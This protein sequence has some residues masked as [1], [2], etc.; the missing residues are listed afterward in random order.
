MS[1]KILI[2]CWW[3]IVSHPY[4]HFCLHIFFLHHHSIICLINSRW[5]HYLT[6]IYTTCTYSFV[7]YHS[8][9]MAVSTEPPLKMRLLFSLQGHKC[10]PPFIIII[11]F[12]II[13]IILEII[14]ILRSIKSVVLWPIT[15]KFQFIK[16]LISKDIVFMAF[17]FIQ[18][19]SLFS[20]GIPQKY[21]F[22][23]STCKFIPIMML[24][25]HIT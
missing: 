1:E 14:I 17:R 7:S 13:N 25:V 12:N 2:H 4:S 9:F 20:I 3:N 18:F 21:I 15:R 11:S 6:I 10:T 8:G 24:M 23:T 22:L 19:L 16:F 5:K